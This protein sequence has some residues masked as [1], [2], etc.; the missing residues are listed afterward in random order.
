MPTRKSAETLENIAINAITRQFS[1][2]GYGDK[3]LIFSIAKVFYKV[4]FLASPDW[5]LRRCKNVREFQLISN[6]L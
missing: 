2:S 6:D 5:F 4:C 1:S 3:R